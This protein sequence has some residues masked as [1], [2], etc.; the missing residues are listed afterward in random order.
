MRRIA[1]NLLEMFVSVGIVVGAAVFVLNAP[2][3][4][5]ESMLIVSAIIASP[6]L[7]WAHIDG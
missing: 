5:L 6:V 2:A 7:L 1:R 3:M 4:S